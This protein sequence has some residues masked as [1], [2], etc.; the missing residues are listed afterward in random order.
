MSVYRNVAY[1]DE[2][3]RPRVSRASASREGASYLEARFLTIL[4]VL[5]LFQQVSRAC[6][7]GDVA[8]EG[9]GEVRCW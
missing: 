2:A 1:G 6:R 4:A 3:Y 7:M 5:E 9:E 8:Y